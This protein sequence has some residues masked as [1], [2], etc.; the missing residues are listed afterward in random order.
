MS[1]VRPSTSCNHSALSV[2][3]KY[4]NDSF[5]VLNRY[6]FCGPKCKSVMMRVA[7]Y[8]SAT[9]SGADAQKARS[10]AFVLGF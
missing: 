9:D 8:N 2:S 5:H 6:S 7:A 4:F 3:Q 10:P 1:R